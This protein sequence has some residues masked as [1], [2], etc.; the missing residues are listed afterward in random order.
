PATQPSHRA[1]LQKRLLALES[2][3]DQLSAKQT[4]SQVAV[5]DQIQN[6]AREQSKLASMID[7]SAGYDPD[8]GFL[9]QTDDG[10]FSIHPS[11]LAQFRYTLNN[12]NAIYPGDGGANGATNNATQNGFEAP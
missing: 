5:M 12:R 3:V 9:L 10:N 2:R 11:V 8:I 4:D 6:D 1:E 7:L